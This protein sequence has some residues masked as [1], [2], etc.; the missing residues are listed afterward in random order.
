MTTES[1]IP[2]NS[3]W[4][5]FTIERLDETVPFDDAKTSPK[6]IIG[7]G[8]TVYWRS[9]FIMV[10]ESGNIEQPMEKHSACSGQATVSKGIELFLGGKGGMVKTG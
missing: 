10:Y 5:S 2:T 7:A 1:E 9:C 4:Q 6:W 8:Q 3:A